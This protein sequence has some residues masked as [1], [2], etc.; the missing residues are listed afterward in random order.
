MLF[1]MGGAVAITAIV[2]LIAFYGANEE[3]I[4]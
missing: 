4:R 1:L 3:P 2:G